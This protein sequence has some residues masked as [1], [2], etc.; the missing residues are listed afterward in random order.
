[1]PAWFSIVCARSS[2]IE[3]IHFNQRSRFGSRPAYRLL[4]LF[5][6]RIG[7]K[8]LNFDISARILG[9]GVTMQDLFK[10]IGIPRIFPTMEIIENSFSSVHVVAVEGFPELGA[11]LFI[12]LMGLLGGWFLSWMLRRS[13]KDE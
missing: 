1:M 3:P 5:N 6:N 8:R 12:F 13:E 7:K 11:T 2:E 9:F 4:P 10:L